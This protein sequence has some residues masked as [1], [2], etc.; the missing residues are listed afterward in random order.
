MATGQTSRAAGQTSRAA[1]QTSRAAG[2][3]SRAA[4][5]TSRAAGQTSRAAGERCAPRSYP[6]AGCQERRAPRSQL[7][8]GC[9]HLERGALT[10]VTAVLPGRRLPGAPRTA[11]LPGAWRSHRRHGGLTW[12][13]VAGVAA[14]TDRRPHVLID[15]GDS[16]QPT[17]AEDGARPRIVA[18]GGGSTDLVAR[19][20]A[21]MARTARA[22]PGPEGRTSGERRLGENVAGC[23]R[24]QDGAGGRAEPGTRCADRRTRIFFNEPLLPQDVVIS[25]L[26]ACQQA[27]A[28]LA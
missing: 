11:L 23:R 28:V 3:T 19:P 14:P 8:A 24:A 1:G 10:G 21:Y 4:G 16:A 20:P 15:G 5:Q 6:D 18:R 27:R 12:A 13:P 22:A 26:K 9:P 2:Q 17:N 25:R 7:D